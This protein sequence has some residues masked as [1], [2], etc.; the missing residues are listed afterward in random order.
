[1]KKHT[2]F[3]V[4]ISYRHDTGFYMAQLLFSKLVSSGYSVFMDKTMDSC[5]Y[6]DKLRSAIHNSRNYVVVLFP[7]DLSEL[8]N[9]DSWLNKEAAWALENSK[10]TIIPLLCDSFEWPAEDSELAGPMQAVKQNNGVRIH[11]DNSLDT[12]LDNLCD[13]FL[14]NVAPAKK[15]INTVEFFR[16]NLGGYTE[17]QP[18]Q[19][20]VA[21]HAGAPWLKAGEQREFITDCMKQGIP[22][23]VLINTEA[24]AESI[25]QHM[26]DE[27]A[28]NDSFA[29]AHAKW[30]QLQER[31]PDLLE[32]RTC[33]IPLI[34]VYH[35]V[36]FQPD[37]DGRQ[38]GEQHVKYYAYGNTRP[39]KVFEHLINSYSPH[40]ALY[41]D[42][43]EFL[44]SKSEKL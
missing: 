19:V 30:K 2:D 43:F 20:D 42:E 32:V 17:R 25:A 33:P 22:W 44:W 28:M 37:E 38:Y 23:R 18:K 11:K 14:K 34:H 29:L 3:D 41:R 13:N 5:R 1:M 21:F 36:A 6:E 7:D 9:P 26:R 15:K 8:K 16:Q 4:F 39:D 27:D 35:C 10:L 40:Y 31:Y 24:A 12:D